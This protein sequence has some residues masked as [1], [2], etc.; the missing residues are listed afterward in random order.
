MEERVYKAMSKVGG[1][2]IAVGVI[3][4]AVGIASGILMIVGGARLL[5]EKS[6]I[7]I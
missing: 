7:L 5:K 6:H 3:V 1:G 4:L 2:S